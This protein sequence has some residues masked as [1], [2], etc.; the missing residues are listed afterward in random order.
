MYIIITSVLTAALFL[1]IGI[2]TYMVL[3]SDIIDDP[4]KEDEVERGFT[5]QTFMRVPKSED[6]IVGRYDTPPMST[7]VVTS[8]YSYSL[9]WS[10][11]MNDIWVDYGS[12]VSVEYT[13]TGSNQVFVEKFGIAAEWMTDP[14]RAEATVGFY[15]DPGDSVDLGT[16]Y[17]WGPNRAGNYTYLI[18]VYI[19]AQ[20]SIGNRWRE[21]GWNSNDQMHWE[22]LDLREEDDYDIVENT[23]YYYDIIN[24]KI[25]PFSPN[26]KDFALGA[27][28]DYSGEYSVFQLCALYDHL[29]ETIN[30]TL[31]PEGEGENV[32]YSPDQT[33]AQCGG[34]CEDHAMLLAAS[35]MTLG[36]TARIYLT[37]NERNNPN[38]NHAFAAIY[39]GSNATREDVIESLKVY[40]NT[41]LKGAWFHDQWGNWLIADPLNSPILGGMPLGCEPVRTEEAGVVSWDFQQLESLV[42]IDVVGIGPFLD[43]T[44]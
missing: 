10:F 28:M 30:Y 27:T 31:D 38:P 32:W 19:H 29:R 37:D 22:A 42:V 12:M 16:L 15:V 4:T 26:V 1:A 25:N 3:F 9:A 41:D 13:N 23:A 18:Q 43:T 14:T 20:Q 36:G 44:S 5:D 34:D 39:I 24:E 35:V 33:I 21:Y 8:G 2:G 11:M 17:F 7:A 40:Y 6:I